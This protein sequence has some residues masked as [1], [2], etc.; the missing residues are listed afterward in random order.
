MLLYHFLAVD[1]A[2]RVDKTSIPQQTL[3]EL[4]LMECTALKPMQTPSGDTMDIT[5]WNGV[6]FDGDDVT[7]IMWRGRGVIAADI[8]PPSCALMRSF[9]TIDLA[10]IPDTVRTFCIIH[11]R[12]E[13]TLYPLQLPRR[14]SYLNCNGNKLAGSCSLDGMPANITHIDVGH[15][16]LSGLLDIPALP[17]TVELFN[18]SFNKF[19][20]SF[21]LEILPAALQCIHLEA[22]AWE[23]VTLTIGPLPPNLK[24]ITVEKGKFAAIVGKG[25]EPFKVNEYMNCQV[26]KRFDKKN[27]P[28]IH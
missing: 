7:E 19:S 21:S 8:A 27:R 17:D 26:I 1:S 28:S 23:M 15:N 25:S 18:C 3:M 10:W 9:G 16:R 24:E 14:L 5:E 4:L 11:L 2:G 20:G 13:G 12:L 6:R 22:N